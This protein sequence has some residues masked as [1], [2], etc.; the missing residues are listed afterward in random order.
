VKLS[1]DAQ[2]SLSVALSEAERL[3]H[4]YSGVEHLLYALTFDE[5]TATVLRHAGADV[6]RLRGDLG[7][8]LEEELAPERTGRRGR[9]QREAESPRLSLALQ[10]V[11][12]WAGAKADSAGRDEIAGA[13]LL[14]ALFDAEDSWAVELLEAQGVTRLDVVSYLAHG[15]SKLA[16]TWRGAAAPPPAP[17]R[18]RPPPADGRTRTSGRAPAAIP[19][20]PSPRS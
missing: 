8:Y 13:D 12:A 6:E 7:A 15:V 4:E 10:R 18:G 16:T 2:I 9:V 14:V 5:A 1:A 20:P 17:P 19:W 11:V 3:G